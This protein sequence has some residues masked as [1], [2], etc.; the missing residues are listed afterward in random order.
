MT[1]ARVT[2]H[3][4]SFRSSGP[5]KRGYPLRYTI[6]FVFTLLTL[7]S[8]VALIV[9]NYIGN[10]KATILAAH[11]LLERISHQVTSQVSALI[12]PVQSV[13]NISSKTI[14]SSGLSFETRLPLLEHF[15]E[16]LRHNRKMASMVVADVDGDFFIVRSVENHLSAS[17]TFG[18]PDGTRFIV[19]GIDREMDELVAEKILFLDENLFSLFE[20]TS[21]ST[22]YD[23][24][25]QGWFK[26]S[27][28]NHQLVTTEDYLLFGTQ[29]I[30][31]TIARRLKEGH[32]V[33]AA[34]LPLKEMSARLAEQRVTPSTELILVNGQGTIVAHSNFSKIEEHLQTMEPSQ[35]RMP[36]LTD[37]D[38]P[39]YASLAKTLTQKQAVGRLDLT[40]ASAKMLGAVTKIPIHADRDL[41]LAAFIPRDELLSGAIQLRN[42]SILISLLCLA[43]TIIIVFW[44]SQ[45]ISTSLRYLSMEAQKIR[46]FK[47][48]TPIRVD[49]RIL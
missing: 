32:G 28:Y 12:L 41:F 8:G 25:R 43:I 1:N 18:A 33:V 40:T 38:S 5:F 10:E 6:A 30:G 21:R 23:H 3:S 15:V 39:L 26:A 7:V 44:L 11:D 36:S 13:I 46:E 19:Q 49:T 2:E 14:H 42:R 37:F 34:D 29:E 24:R 22:T 45:R 31:L 27:I 16:I 9:F 35:A 20:K 47:L 4:L 17:S 48:D